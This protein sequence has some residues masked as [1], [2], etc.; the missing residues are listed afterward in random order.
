L[1][2]KKDNILGLEP[3]VEVG[4]KAEVNICVAIDEE[5]QSSSKSSAPQEFVASSP[6]CVFAAE[7]FVAFV[8]V[9]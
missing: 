9:G 4:D 3:A 7:G 8:G 6:D 1:T 5:V 2:G